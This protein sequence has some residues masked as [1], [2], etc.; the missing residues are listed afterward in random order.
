MMTMPTRSQPI[1]GR[2]S[3]S[4]IAVA[5]PPTNAASHAAGPPP[6]DGPA[7]RVAMNPGGGGGAGGNSGADF[8]VSGSQS[9]LVTVASGGAGSGGV[10]ACGWVSV[11]VIGGSSA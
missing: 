7:H 2:V 10:A 9:A 3:G 6:Y 8:G 11:V 4:A 5:S 1:P